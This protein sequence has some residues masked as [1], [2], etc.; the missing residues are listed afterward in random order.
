MYILTTSKR[1][2]Q[3]TF[4][5]LFFVAAIGVS[6]WLSWRSAHVVGPATL[7]EKIRST[8]QVTLDLI[9]VENIR[10]ELISTIETRL[11]DQLSASNIEQPR[12]TAKL[13]LPDA[14]DFLSKDKMVVSQV[15]Q[16]LKKLPKAENAWQ[17][18]SAESEQ[19]M[20][21]VLDKCLLI[22]RVERHWILQSIGV[23]ERPVSTSN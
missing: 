12:Q 3:I 15:N 7:I 17:Q 4:L 18:L 9:D 23:C 16:Q 19:Q 20:Y 13:M 8:Q 6:Y 10:A 14:T 21:H 22:A 2:K 5:L 1:I 11:I